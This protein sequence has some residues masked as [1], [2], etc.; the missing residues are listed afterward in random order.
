MAENDLME[1]IVV[2]Q[3]IR[4][5]YTCKNGIVKVTICRDAKSSKDAEN[6]HRLSESRQGHNQ[7]T[8]GAASLNIVLLVQ[9]GR[10]Q[11]KVVRIGTLGCVFGHRLDAHIVLLVDLVGRLLNTLHICCLLVVVLRDVSC[12]P[13]THSRVH[14]VIAQQ[15][16]S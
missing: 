11:N 9:C 8:T 14:H 12:L 7:A 3:T 10:S 4:I 16:L 6:R 2:C 15:L 1:C 13:L 5:W